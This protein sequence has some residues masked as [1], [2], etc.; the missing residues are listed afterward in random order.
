MEWGIWSRAPPWGW[1]LLCRARRGVCETL[2]TQVVPCCGLGAPRSAEGG[3]WLREGLC[4]AC[5]GPGGRGSGQG[6]GGPAGGWE[7]RPPS[8]PQLSLRRKV[9]PEERSQW[10]ALAAPLSLR[11]AGCGRCR[12]PKCVAVGRGGST[13]PC[14]RPCRSQRFRCRERAQSWSCARSS[15]W[16]LG[17]SCDLAACAPGKGAWRGT[18]RSF[19][20]TGTASG[21]AAPLVAA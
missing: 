11:S 14:P 21:A 18:S 1:A 7:R 8:E 4:G 3:V 2:W 9:A 16:V 6:P 19:A 17:S 20:R 15:R 10:Q 13:P 5:A 12:R